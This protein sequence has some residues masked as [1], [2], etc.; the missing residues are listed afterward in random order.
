M[1]ALVKD[2]ALEDR[3]TDLPRYCKQLQALIAELPSSYALKGWLAAQ[4][5]AVSH[6][7][8]LQG[9][10]KDYA[11]LGRDASARNERDSKGSRFAGLLTNA[12]QVLTGLES[13][14]ELAAKLE[15]TMY[16]VADSGMNLKEY[17]F[18]AFIMKTLETEPLQDAMTLK[19]TEHCSSM[20]ACVGKIEKVCNRFYSKDNLWK[21]DLKEDAPL[22]EVLGV[23]SKTIGQN[24]PGLI[25]AALTE[26]DE[27]RAR[28][29]THTMYIYLYAADIV[30]PP[31]I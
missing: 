7:V 1:A 10:A 31:A 20:R 11:E 30:R 2:V 14:Q 3:G 21:K 27:A 6:C 19:L 13:I 23:A 15:T 18:T 28:D 22:K 26:L 5:R 8:N 16:D 4:L 17:C 9:L 24:D 25:R 12:R 29:K